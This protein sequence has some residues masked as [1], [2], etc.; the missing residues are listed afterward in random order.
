MTAKMVSILY[1]KFFFV[2]LYLIRKITMEERVCS[3]HD[4][5]GALKS[6][7]DNIHMSYNTSYD[8]SLACR[9]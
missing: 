4:S 5:P 8:A 3:A 1:T 6:A 9:Q 2:R 7:T